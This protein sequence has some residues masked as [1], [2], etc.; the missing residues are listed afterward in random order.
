MEFTNV[1]MI[2][3]AEIVVYEFTGFDL[4]HCG[5]A[6]QRY[7]FGIWV[8]NEWMNLN[9]LYWYIGLIMYSNENYCFRSRCTLILLHLKLI[10]M[11][12]FEKPVLCLLLCVIYNIKHMY[13]FYVFR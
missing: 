10:K 2:L 5:D 9:M 4:I 3:T 13:F 7:L 12:D 6:Y 11:N 1:R 8:K